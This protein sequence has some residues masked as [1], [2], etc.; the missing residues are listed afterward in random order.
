MRGNFVFSSIFGGISIL[1]VLTCN[2][3]CKICGVLLAIVI[4]GG[5][6]NNDD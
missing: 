3:I 5:K 1:F 6:G 4:L 2:R